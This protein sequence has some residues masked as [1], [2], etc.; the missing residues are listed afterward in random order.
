MI[1][2]D[3]YELINLSPK[4]SGARKAK[5]R[6]CYCDRTPRIN[7]CNWQPGG[8]HNRIM[9]TLCVISYRGGPARQAI[10][11]CTPEDKQRR[12]CVL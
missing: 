3:I 1:L 2:I 10:Q 7:D 9:C 12:R 4:N 5:E 6:I 11:S 8:V